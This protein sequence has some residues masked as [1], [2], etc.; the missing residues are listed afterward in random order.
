MRVVDGIALRLFII[1]TLLTMMCGASF[2]V[3]FVGGLVN[4]PLMPAGHV[5][6]YMWFFR[7]GVEAVVISGN[8]GWREND[9]CTAEG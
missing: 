1:Q 9:A 7:D 6:A 3:F 2:L 8:N 5:A 4:L